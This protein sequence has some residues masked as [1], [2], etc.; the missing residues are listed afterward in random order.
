MNIG[1]NNFFDK[2]ILKKN[3]FYHKVISKIN[4]SV[5]ELKVRVYSLLPIV[6]RK[7]V[8]SHKKIYHNF[9]RR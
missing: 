4:V 2:K 7:H 8:K 5:S 6:N 9:F 3:K 1:I